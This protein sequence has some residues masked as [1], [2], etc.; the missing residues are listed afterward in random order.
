[1]IKQ[2][3]R[4]VI[5]GALTALKIDL[6]LEDITIEIPNNPEHGDYATNIAMRAAKLAK[7]APPIIA[8]Q[9]VEAL[10]KDKAAAARYTFS[11]ING[12]INVRIQD[13][14]LIELLVNNIKPE[15]GKSNY[16]KGQKVLLEFVSAN[17]T[18]PLHIGHG[19][20]AALGDVLARVLSY[21]GFEVTKEFYI[22]DQ[23]KQI[24]NLRASVKAIKEGKP[25][26]EDGYHGHYVKEL[27]AGTDDSVEVLLAEQQKVLSMMLVQFDN[28]F[29]E[30]SL[31]AKGSVQKALDI[32]KKKKAVEE[33]DGALWFRSTDYGDDKDRVLIKENGEL[34]YFAADIAYHENKLERGFDQ[35][36]NIWGADHHGYIQRVQAALKALTGDKSFNK[37]HVL[38]GQLVSL[39]RDGAPVR[40]S[41]RTGDMITLQ[42]VIEEIGSDATRYFLVAR[43]PDTQLDF[44]LEVAK[45]KNDENPVYYVQYAHARICSILRQPEADVKGKAVHAKLEPLERKILLVLARV[46]D[47]LEMIA[48]NYGVHRLTFLAQE[49]ATL[50]H[51]FYHEYRVLSDNKEDTLWRLEFIKA[52]KQVLEIIFNLLGVSAPEKM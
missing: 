21:T 46:P 6:T 14:Y 36:I 41:K 39:Y 45:K 13:A 4:N 9:L 8:K 10:Q 52:I 7:K 50:F 19:R 17:P 24:E 20:W 38:L 44:D 11:V 34:T 29:S 48:D 23:G 1:M 42:E 31:H 27:A 49:L 30:K 43:S 28:W 40:M 51:S 12:F 33:K 32:L 22:N 15:F 37:L 18:G 25:V 5:S 35:L 16:G 47:D 26:P 2:D 3:L